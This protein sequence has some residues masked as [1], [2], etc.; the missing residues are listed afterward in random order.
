MF[1]PFLIVVFES[2]SCPQCEKVDLK[3]IKSRLERV[4]IYKRCWNT[5][6]P[7]GPGGFF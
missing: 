6:E 7:A 4:Q 1:E 2:L 5:E 3:I